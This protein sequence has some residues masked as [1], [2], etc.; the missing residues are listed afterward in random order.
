M[1]PRILSKR[2]VIRL[3]ERAFRGERRP[4][5]DELAHCEQCSLWV[6]R[7][8][9]FCPD[10]W[11]QIPDADIAYEAEALTAVKPA[12]WRF[13]LPAYLVWHLENFDDSS[14]NTVHHLI[15]QLTLEESTD[16]H[17]RDGYES[18]SREQRRAVAAF[19]RFIARQPH[20]EFLARDAS[21]AL[22]AHWEQYERLD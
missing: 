14:S 11:R 12:A 21:K 13:L 2:S 7:F 1:S 8:L 18:L 10:D 6:E 20:D 4:E 9:E 5:R 3:I 22:S 16:A 19:L 17:I 15:Y